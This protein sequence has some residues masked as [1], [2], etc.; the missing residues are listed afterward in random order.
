MVAQQCTQCE[1]RLPAWDAAPAHTQTL[2]PTLTPTPTTT[3]TL[4]LPLT[5]DPNPN[6]NLNPYSTLNL[7]QP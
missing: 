6:P 3:P 2:T 7:T 5:T 4:T 1:S